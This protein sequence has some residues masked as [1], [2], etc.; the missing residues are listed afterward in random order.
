MILVAGGVYFMA[1][2]NF[3]IEM[4]GKHVFEYSYV[5]QTHMILICVYV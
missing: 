1:G 2:L 4:G 5:L 3:V